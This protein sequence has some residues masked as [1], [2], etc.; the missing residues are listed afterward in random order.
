MVRL[1]ILL[2]E[3][4]HVKLQRGCLSK[5]HRAV[6]RVDDLF[7]VEVVTL[8]DPK[9]AAFYWCRALSLEAAKL[10]HEVSVDRIVRTHYEPQMGEYFGARVRDYYCSGWGEWNLPINW[11]LSEPA[12]LSRYRLLLLS[13]RVHAGGRLHLPT[14]LHLKIEE[15][16]AELNCSSDHRQIS[17]RF[18]EKIFNVPISSDEPA[19]DDYMEIANEIISLTPF[20]AGPRS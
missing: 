13:M 8:E 20:A 1:S 11:G 14:D 9:A 4:L 7:G 19:S 16:S 10:V 3:I 17:S 18:V 6:L 5:S 15:R 12:H 2:H